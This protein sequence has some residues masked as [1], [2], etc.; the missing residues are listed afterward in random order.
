VT[1]GRFIWAKFLEALGL[2]AVMIALVTGLYGDAW[3]EL[4][5]FLGGIGTFIVGRQLEKEKNAAARTADAPAQ[6][7]KREVGQE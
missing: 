4:A 2:A 5:L 6:H 3:G 1:R 7:A